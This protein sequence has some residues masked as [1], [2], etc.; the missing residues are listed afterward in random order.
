MNDTF[1]LIDDITSVN[2]DGVFQNL[3][4]NIY[5][6]SLVLNKENDDDSIC[7]M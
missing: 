7:I 3:V 1:R 5:P 4:G 2:S 6:E